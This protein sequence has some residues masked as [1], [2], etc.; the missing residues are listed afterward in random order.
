MSN[1]PARTTLV[2]I[3]RVIHEAKQ[4]GES[5]VAVR[6]EW[7]NRS[8]AP[9]PKGRCAWCGE[10]ES[11]SALVL[12]LGTEPRTHAW[13]HGECW[14]P[15]QKARRVEAVKALTRVGGLAGD[16]LSERS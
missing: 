1:R 5:E 9:S 11:T 14:L 15:R 16:A 2:E 3:E 7:L 6:V 4:A 12:P 13:L 8:P 10:H